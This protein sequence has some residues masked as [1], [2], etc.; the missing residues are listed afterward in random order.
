M[1]I[2]TVELGRKAGRLQSEPQKLPVLSSEV[3]VGGPQVGTYQRD[4]HLDL[5][6]KGRPEELL[7]ERK[8]IKQLL[9]LSPGEGSDLS[10]VPAIIHG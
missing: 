9:I 4:I 1:L 10:K 8:E 7:S 6:V 3:G 2:N 5:R